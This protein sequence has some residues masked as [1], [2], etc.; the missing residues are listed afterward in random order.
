MK[1]SRH[2]PKPITF[3]KKF[4]LPVAAFAT[5]LFVACSSPSTPGEEAIQ[6]IEEATEKIEKAENLAEFQA[7]SNE[8]EAK[9]EELEKK[10]PDY[11][12]TAE[13]EKKMEEVQSK[14]EEVC[15]Q[16][17]MQFIGDLTGGGEG[18]GEE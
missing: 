10:N 15:Q 2:I 5:F 11:K 7:I 1:G 16:K 6:M 8:M 14:F 17:A 4:L 18:E 3:M 12:P 13:E 9:F